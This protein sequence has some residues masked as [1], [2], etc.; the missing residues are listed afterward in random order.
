MNIGP[1]GARHATVSIPG[2]G[3]SYRHTFSPPDQISPQEPALPSGTPEF[4]PSVYPPSDRIGPEMTEIR[5]ASTEALTSASLKDLKAILAD[6]YHQREELTSEIGSTEREVAL[7]G[8]A[9]RSWD[10][11]FLLKRLFKAK[12]AER[13]ERFGT[14]E[15]KLAELPEQFSL[16]KVVA[17]IHVE[18]E[19]A[20]LYYRLRD[21]FASLSAS[22]AI[23][24]ML[25]ERAT[26]RVVE[27]TTA[28]R[29]VE[30]KRVQF[31]LSESDLFE[32]DQKVPYLGNCNGGD[33]Y[34]YPG[35]VLYR[36]S[37]QAFSVIECTESVI[38]FIPTRFI[39]EEPIPIDAK[40]VDR[41]WAK[42]NKDG[43]PDRRFAHNH[44]IPVALYGCITFKSP[45]GLNEEYQFS[46][47]ELADRFV[48]SWDAFTRSLQGKPPQQSKLTAV[49]QKLL[50]A[51]NSGQNVKVTASF[52]EKDGVWRGWY[53]EHPSYLVSA[54][55]K[56]ELLARLNDPATIV[57]ALTAS[58]E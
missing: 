53:N 51:I 26:N 12:F 6:A 47:A 11:G 3:L 29:V 24:D 30:R 10:R 13:R 18:G 41:V 49:A 2:S 37:K 35:F 57:A 52:E 54:S 4:S 14:V 27:R 28:T 34:L 32:W 8:R 1:D 55:S 22:A 7:F 43:S 15:A 9:F 58:A 36:V 25:A 23:W 21:D 39:E 20:E 44:Q 19:Q 31:K 46:N 42:A 5:S 48:K 38:K 17:E 45:T 56:S 50:D 16:S 33:L 40:V